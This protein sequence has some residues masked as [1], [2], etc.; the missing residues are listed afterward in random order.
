MA[1][2]DCRSDSLIMS[3]ASFSHPQCC[4]ELTS[5]LEH[6][7]GDIS[8]WRHQHLCSLPVPAS[9]PPSLLVEQKYNHPVSP[10]S[11]RWGGW[12]S[13]A[14][15]HTCTVRQFQWVLLNPNG[16]IALR[17]KENEMSYLK[18]LSSGRFW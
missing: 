18:E 11:V 16:W 6:S 7:L 2:W 4:P 12:G 9:S 8:V 15:S 13:P 14:H 1:A 10:L 5:H 3:H 17:S